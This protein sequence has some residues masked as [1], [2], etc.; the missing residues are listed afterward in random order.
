MILDFKPVFTIRRTS[1]LDN[2]S[3]EE[4]IALLPQTMQD[5]VNRIEWVFDNINTLADKIILD[6]VSGEPVQGRKFKREEILLLFDPEKVDHDGMS[7]EDNNLVYIAADPVLWARVYLKINPRVYQILVLR[8]SKPR[9]IMRWGR[10][11]GKSATMAIRILWR[12]MTRPGNKTLLVAPM[13]SHVDVTWDMIIEFIKRDEELK[14][15]WDDKEIK[16]KKQPHH[17]MEFPNGSVVKGFTSGMRS[18]NHA[19]NVRGQEADD[20]YC[21]EIDYM[22]AGDLKALFAIVRRT[23]KGGKKYMHVSSTPSGRRDMMYRFSAEFVRKHPELYNEYYFPTHS[24]VN[25]DTA[26]DAEF[27]MVYTH[28]NYLHE[29]IADFGEETAGVFLQSHIERAQ[30]HYPEGYRYEKSGLLYKPPGARRVVGVDWDKI[31]AG[32]NIVITDFMIWADF[33]EDDIDVG[34]AKIIARF[35]VPRGEFTLNEGKDLIKRIFLTYAPDLIVLD[36]GY[37]E[38]QY[39]D[40]TLAGINDK[41]YSGMQHVIRPFNFHQNVEIWDPTTREKVNKEAKDYMVDQTIKLFENDQL[42]LNRLDSHEVPGL[43]D[44]ISQFESYVIVGLSI[45]GKPRYEAGNEEIGDHALDAFMLTVLGAVTEWGSFSTA[46]RTPSPVAVNFDVRRS[47][48]VL[49]DTNKEFVTE[50]LSDVKYLRRSLW[51]QRGRTDLRRNR[52]IKRSSF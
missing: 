44:I 7:E 41:R 37:G 14:Q 47:T 10:R 5:E 22:N 1:A 29:I 48:G 34:R 18:K 38:G 49:L 32:V 23:S 12:S 52:T 35:E 6:P 30:A 2:L 50:D 33:D 27:R 26:Q 21:D 17:Q 24:D 51:K 15:M 39:E 3:K 42:I 25:Y 28:N 36:R 46:R 9:V 4:L 11:A 43:T 31:G 20:L 45:Y 40:L 13:L 16:S 19:D 8:E